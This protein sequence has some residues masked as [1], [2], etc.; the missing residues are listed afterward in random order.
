MSEREGQ[1]LSLEEPNADLS[2]SYRS[3]VAEF[4]EHGEN[5][6]PF[7]LAFPHDDFPKLL[8]RLAAES[9][10]EGIPAGFVPHSTFWLVLDGTTVV[11][12]SNLRHRLT[13]SLRRDGGHIGYGVRPSA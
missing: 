13:D 4:V 3:L 6:I 1:R 2:D 10:G 5:L 9:R 8:E 11:G 7:P 12:V